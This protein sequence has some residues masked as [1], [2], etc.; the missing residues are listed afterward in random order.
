MQIANQDGLFVNKH[1]NKKA[2]HGPPLALVT[3]LR[4]GLAAPE[5]S[6][7]GVS[8][9]GGLRTHYGKMQ[10]GFVIDSAKYV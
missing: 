9:A 7:G 1:I 5:P 2:G 3:A 8:P 10:L 4:I 6:W